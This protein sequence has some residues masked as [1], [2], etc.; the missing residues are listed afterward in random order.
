M[1]SIDAA[2][3]L[4]ALAVFLSQM[5]YALPVTSDAYE[6]LRII[7]YF[8]GGGSFPIESTAIDAPP[9]IYPPIFSLSVFSF[10]T[11]SG[12]PANFTLGFFSYLF[13]LLIV[14]LV[15]L[16]IRNAYSGTENRNAY[17]G[18]GKKSFSVEEKA[19]LG[20]L[21]IFTLPILIYRLITPIPE[22]LGLAFFLLSAYFYQKKNYK[23]LLIVLAIF[24]LAHSRSFAFTIITLGMAAALRKDYLQAAKS[25][26]LGLAVFAIYHLAFPIYASGFENP[27]IT[28]PA[29]F[30]ML[31]I[32]AIAMTL[33]GTYVIFRKNYKFDFL[34]ASA[35]FAFILTYFLLPFP[36]RHVIFLILPIS[37]L[38]AHALSYD[39]RVLA[40]FSVFLALSM[41][42]A[43]QMREAPLTAQ[44]VEMMREFENYAGENSIAPF[45]YNYALPY[46]AD[47]KVVVGAFAEALPDGVQ[48]SSDL[49]NY[50]TGGESGQKLAVL[51][52]Y[53]IQV[54]FFEKSEG[55]G[56]AEVNSDRK[57][58]ESDKI[59]AYSFKTGN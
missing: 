36:F 51:E 13:V 11:L 35:I 52:K 5:Y 26:I 44:S 25:S 45:K 34:C 10:K 15:Y 28:V 22:T 7:N 57:L 1:K 24:P 8:E 9:Y 47:K 42:Q 40:V 54:G 50:F 41:V 48:R 6:N 14:Y 46:F 19:A 27:S 43:I 56:S 2:L 16:L 33:A 38:V 3:L 17:S 32:L 30:E 4:G 49:N 58:L 18:N 12:F 31:P 29:L 20:V 23:L 53:S 37:F 39:R 55:L 59:A 21:G